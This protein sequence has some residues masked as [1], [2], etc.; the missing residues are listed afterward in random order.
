MWGL[1]GSF[2]LVALFHR[3]SLGVAS[4]EAQRRLGV[5]TGAITALSAV[6]LCLYLAM[7]VPAGLLADRVGPRRT[8]IWGLAAMGGGE[9][10]FGLSSSFPP[11]LA[12]R[13]LVGVGDACT[14]LNVLRVAANWLPARRY[15]L[16]VALTGLLGSGGQ[17]ATTAPLHALLTG[18][19]WTPTFA[20]SGVVTAAL[21]LLAA[22]RLRDHP[23]GRPAR[24]AGAHE[25]VERVLATLRRAWSRRGTRH[26]F[27]AH[28]TLMS[29]FVVL[30]GFWGYPF[31]VKGQGIPAAE[32][33]ALL[34]APVVAF[35]ATAPLLGWLAGRRPHR[36]AQIVLGAAAANALAVAALV[37]WPGPRVPAAVAGAAL[38]IAGAAGAASMLGFDLAREQSREHDGGSASGLVN[39]GGFSAAIAADVAIGALV[40]AQLRPSAA[41]SYQLALAPLLALALLGLARLARLAQRP[42]TAR[43]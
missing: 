10:V 42:S 11:A 13:A 22:A 9:L 15:A 12:G 28:F 4:L 24:G 37:C 19:G 23:P 3:M 26:G 34:S 36:R 14:F 2:Y 40:G 17:L 25:P 35:A 18:L 5:H 38:T 39:T 43:A 7:Q 27:W 16:A 41:A 29:P 20:A 1:A 33:S 31:L 6:Q 8:L 21:A 30:C 32:A